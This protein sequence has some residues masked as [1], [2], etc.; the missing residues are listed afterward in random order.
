M[1]NIF[2][3]LF[4]AALLPTSRAGDER[5][6]DIGSITDLTSET[7]SIERR[8][9]LDSIRPVAEKQLNQKL[10]FRVSSLPT[11]DE[12]AVALLMPLTTELKPI[13]WRLTNFS[14]EYRKKNLTGWLEVLLKK[15]GMKWVVVDFRVGLRDYDTFSTWGKN[16][17]T[18]PKTLL[19]IAGVATNCDPCE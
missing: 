5:N 1:K 13:D 3:A 9:I 7:T 18:L 19:T 15:Q 6:I 14:V 11:N 12:W 17:P 10:K 16:F 8:K 2:L 4:L